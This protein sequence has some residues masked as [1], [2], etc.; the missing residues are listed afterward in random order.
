[1]WISM[2]RRGLPRPRLSQHLGSRLNSHRLVDVYSIE[3]P[4]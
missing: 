3:T 1:L 2:A 4:T